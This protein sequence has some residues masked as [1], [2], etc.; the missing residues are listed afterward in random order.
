MIKGNIDGIKEYILNEL[1]SLH[2]VQVTKSKLIE[3][4]MLYTIA[5]ISNKINREINIAILRK[6]NVI[7]ISIGE[8]GRV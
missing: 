2:E 4:E 3:E 7:E 8:R 5:D 1:D 6:G